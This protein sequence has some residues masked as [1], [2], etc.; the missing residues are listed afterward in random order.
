MERMEMEFKA[1]WFLNTKAIG[2]QGVW[3]LMAPG[4]T[5]GPDQDGLSPAGTM[6][7]S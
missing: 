2:I 7:A 4:Q 3:F 5:L 6:A 1:L